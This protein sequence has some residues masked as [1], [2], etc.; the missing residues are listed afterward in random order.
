MGKPNI[1]DINALAAGKHQEMCI[2]VALRYFGYFHVFLNF[3]HAF[4]SWSIYLNTML[5][6]Q[7]IHFTSSVLTKLVGI[8]PGIVFSQLEL[9][10]DSSGTTQEA[11]RF[12]R[13][14]GD[15]HLRLTLVHLLQGG[16]DLVRLS[17]ISN[18]RIIT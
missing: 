9:K 18:N 16:C 11:S 14:L 8:I 4:S 7:D 13:H 5:E 3:S 10:V 17:C 15:S 6:K 2:G 12:L 1:N